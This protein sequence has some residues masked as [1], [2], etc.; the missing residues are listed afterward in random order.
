MS[1]FIENKFF[2]F[3]LLIIFIIHQYIF[4]NFF[5]N[6]KGLLGHDY[7]YFIPTFI[8]GK[9]CFLNNFLSVPWFTPSFCCGI[10]FYADPQSM[11]YSIPQIIFLI[12][13]PVLSVKIIFFILSSLSYIGTFLLINKNFKFDIYTSLLCASLFLFN[14][15][16]I[17]RAIAGHVA[18]LSYVFVPIYSYFLIKSFENRTNNSSYVYLILSSIIF[19]NFFHSGSGP[20]ILIIFTSI[21]TVLLFYAHLVNSFKIF[22]ELVLSLLLGIS[23]SLSKLTATLFFLENFPRKYPA[24]EFHSLLF[25]VK[26]FFVT[27]FYKPNEKQFNENVESMFSF[28]IH[29]M[30]YNV[31]IIPIILLFFI[32][33][34]NKKVFKLNYH[35]IRFLF[36]VFIIF[37]IPIFLNV[38]LFGQ[39]QLISK[40]PILNSTWVQFRWMAI[41]ILPII[42]IS[43]LIIKNLNFNNYKKKNIIILLISILLIQNSIRDKSWHLNDQKYSTKN[44]IDFSL[45]IKK[46]V[47]P[48]ILGP[49]ILMDSTNTPKKI[50]NKNDMFFSSYSPLLC[51]QP[52]F[53]Y[54][55]EK[56][57]AKRIIFNSKKIFNDQ[58]FI[59]YSDKFDKKNN[60]FMFFNPSCFWFPE[61][62]NCLPGDTFKVSEKE[63]LIK[64]ANYKKFKFE[65]NKIQTF[66]N[67]ISVFT[68]IGSLLY[69]TWCLIIFIYNFRKKY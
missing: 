37:S 17:Y 65:Q 41:Y 33:F 68:I 59:L 35:N 48:E 10:P 31:S 14:G 27:F 36:F 45:K 39:F 21:V 1:K 51:N 50:S 24:T 22:K 69:L 25:F 52:I 47:N 63:K 61:E 64:F 29:E 40:V 7:E 16:F 23:I 20:I 54:G 46:G 49:A 19:A 2:V 12:F 55:L 34:L 32:P 67:Y 62:N 66:S 53:G 11:Y 57:N 26:T 38:N 3:L 60:R 58:S 42:I 44:A 4:Q 13:N 9:I 15:F 6:S 43:A 30:E 18:Y 56:L 28:G 5:P 8:F